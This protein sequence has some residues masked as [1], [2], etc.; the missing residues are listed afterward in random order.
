MWR[1]WNGEEK[2]SHR[3]V[4]AN[5]TIFPSSAFKSLWSCCLN[6]GPAGPDEVLCLLQVLAAAPQLPP[7]LCPPTPLR[8]RLAWESVVGWTVVKNVS[9]GLGSHP[10]GTV[11]RVGIIEASHFLK[12]SMTRRKIEFMSICL[13]NQY[14]STRPTRFTIEIQS[15]RQSIVNVQATFFFRWWF[16]QNPYNDVNSKGRYR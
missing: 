13:L 16:A 10:T 15:H 5:H 14:V 4:S 7:Q 2:Q 1:E 9:R 6:L 12:R 3:T 8:P 11:V